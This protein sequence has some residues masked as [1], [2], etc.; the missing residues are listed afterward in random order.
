MRYSVIPV[1]GFHL[2]L[3]Q[4]Q[5]GLD[6]E[7]SVTVGSWWYAIVLYHNSLLLSKIILKFSQEEKSKYFVFIVKVSD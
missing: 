5:E 6:R 3:S 4:N 1:V 7:S 2:S